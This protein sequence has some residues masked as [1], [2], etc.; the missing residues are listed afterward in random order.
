MKPKKKSLR[1]KY[2]LASS[3][4]EFYLILIPSNVRNLRHHPQV[5]RYFVDT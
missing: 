5:Q 3:P 2:V 1:S 4:W